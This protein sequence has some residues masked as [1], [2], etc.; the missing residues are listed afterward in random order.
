MFQH[1]TITRFVLLPE[2]MLYFKNSLSSQEAFRKKIKF[3]G[4]F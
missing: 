1:D 4:N 2:V 3:I